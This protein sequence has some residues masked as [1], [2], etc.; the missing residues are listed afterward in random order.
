MLN[1]TLDQLVAAHLGITE[2]HSVEV[3]VKPD[4][5]LPGRSVVWVNV[6]GVCLLRICRVRTDHVVIDA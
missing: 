1:P 3:Q 5:N 6:D 4:M 2:P